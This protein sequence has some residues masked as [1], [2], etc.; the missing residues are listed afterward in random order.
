MRKTYTLEKEINNPDLLFQNLKDLLKKFLEHFLQLEFG[1]DLLFALTGK[2]NTE[3]IYKVLFSSWEESFYTTL[4]K[5]GIQ[6]T[7]E[8]FIKA[9]SLT[10]ALVTAINAAEVLFSPNKSPDQ[11]VL[12]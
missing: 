4:D 12:N 5:Q 3:E 1:R 6:K 2:E 9:L 11:V 10:L 7:K 8:M